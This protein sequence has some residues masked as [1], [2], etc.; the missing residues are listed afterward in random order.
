M[1]HALSG[2][3]LIWS[4][5]VL[6]VCEWTQSSHSLLESNAN[7]LSRGWRA[8]HGG[9]EATQRSAHMKIMCVCCFTFHDALTLKVS[10]ESQ[11]SLKS[12]RESSKENANIRRFATTEETQ[13]MEKKQGGSLLLQG[14]ALLSS[15]RSKV[16]NAWGQHEGSGSS[17]GAAWVN[18]TQ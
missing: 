7:Q 3:F 10:L 2:P 11:R 4:T 8:R 17:R 1:S 12:W 16:G 13:G 5:C 14:I 18:P 9:L 6:L 15:A